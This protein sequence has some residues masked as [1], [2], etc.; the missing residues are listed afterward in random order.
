[1]CP[2]W[3]FCRSTIGAAC[4][5]RKIHIEYTEEYDTSGGKCSLTCGE[6]DKGTYAETYLECRNCL[7]TSSGGCI[8]CGTNGTR[9]TQ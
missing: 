5:H 8:P 9:R 4:K 3:L 1:M 2:N 6:E 7:R